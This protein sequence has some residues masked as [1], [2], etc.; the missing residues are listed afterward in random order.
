[1]IEIE[2][3]GDELKDV[4]KLQGSFLLNSG[5]YSDT[6]FDKYL[7]ISDAKLLR[8]I[9]GSMYGLIPDDS[10]ILAGLESGGALLATPLSLVRGMDSVFVRKQ[11]KEYGTAKR[12]EGPSVRG[13]RLCM[14]EDV[15]TSGKAVYEARAALE[16]EGAIVN[17][18]I[19]LILRREQTHLEMLDQGLMLYPLFHWETM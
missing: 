8:R 15:V 10:E 7:A 14:V 4:C 13:R 19:C 1:M 9:V 2:R 11:A 3:L 12:I 6:Y 18:A 16:E 17:E 5:V